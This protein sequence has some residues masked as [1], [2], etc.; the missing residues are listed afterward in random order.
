MIVFEQKIKEISNMVCQF[1]VSTRMNLYLI[2]DNLDISDF[3]L[4]MKIRSEGKGQV[5]D[6]N[7]FKNALHIE[8]CYKGLKMSFKFFSNGNIHISGIRDVNTP[9]EC[10][11]SILDLIVEKTRDPETVQVNT[12]SSI[13]KT[14]DNKWI[15]SRKENSG[16]QSFLK[17]VRIIDS[18]LYLTDPRETQV[19]IRFDDQKT[20]FYTVSH[21][22]SRRVYDNTVRFLGDSQLT[23]INRKN[24]PKTASYYINNSNELRYNVNNKKFGEITEPEITKVPLESVPEFIEIDRNPFDD[25]EIIIS[26]CK[27]SNVNIKYEISGFPEDCFFDKQAL[28]EILK[29]NGISNNYNPNNYSALK[30][31]MYFHDGKLHKEEVPGS[32]TI[33]AQI[34]GEKI[35]IASKSISQNEFFFKFLLMLY[36]KF[37]KSFL[38][39]KAPKK[40]LTES[41]TIFDLLEYLE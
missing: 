27:I 22:K 25:V 5:N 37:H 32:S 38:I 1:E 13:I 26:D 19:H 3:I 2:Y 14:V 8:T 31:L 23:M 20:C 29:K 36:T 41:L 18:E 24:L 40:A 10:L 7:A 9:K 39:T 16:S 34:H 4:G 35:N 28:S 21:I 33:K 12:D 30:I 17:A 6:K 11:Q 15:I